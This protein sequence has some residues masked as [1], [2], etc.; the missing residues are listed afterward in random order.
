M[1][2]AFILDHHIDGSVHDGS[3]SSPLAMELL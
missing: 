3:N 1:T 2:A